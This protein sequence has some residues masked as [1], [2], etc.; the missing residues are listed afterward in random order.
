M[1]SQSSISDHKHARCSVVLDDDE[2]ESILALQKKSRQ[3]ANRPLESSETTLRPSPSVV[4][5][6]QQPGDSL[7]LRF[8]TEETWIALLQLEFHKSYFQSL[9]QRLVAL[10]ERKTI[11]YPPKE[12]VF[13]ALNLCPFSTTKVIIIGQD[14]YHVCCCFADDNQNRFLVSVRTGLL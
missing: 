14:C 13:S 9:E 12:L 3:T 10:E 8:L 11:V 2:T 6:P 5:K 4:P 1:A 7:L